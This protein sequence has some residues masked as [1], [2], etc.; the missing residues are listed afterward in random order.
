MKIPFVSDLF[1]ATAK[2]APLVDVFQGKHPY[3]ALDGGLD[4]INDM[5]RL[6]ALRQIVAHS[7][8]VS[9]HIYESHGDHHGSFYVIDPMQTQIGTL[10]EVSGVGIIRHRREIGHQEALAYLKQD[11][12]EMERGFPNGTLVVESRCCRSLERFAPGALKKA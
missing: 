6:T 11:Q 10:Y 4:R 7:D 12:V 5:D 8:I 2:P 9:T 1:S 3:D